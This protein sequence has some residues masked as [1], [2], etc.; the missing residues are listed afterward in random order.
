MGSGAPISPED[1]ATTT[2]AYVFSNLGV[3]YVGAW[4]IIQ[5]RDYHIACLD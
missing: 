3:T 5:V 1:G 2:E 4:N